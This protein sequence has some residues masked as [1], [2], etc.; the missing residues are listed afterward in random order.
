[1]TWEK[2]NAYCELKK[3]MREADNN[4]LYDNLL[5]YLGT[6]EFTRKDYNSKIP[7]APYRRTPSPTL[8]TMRRK[9]I[10]R[11]VGQETYTIEI[12]GKGDEDFAFE[13]P[14]GKILTEEQFCEI[15][16]EERLKMTVKV[17][18]VKG[19]K[20][21]EGVRYYYELVKT[22]KEELYKKSIKLLNTIFDVKG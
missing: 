17:T 19:K 8:E 20:K 10:I 3:I 2:Y 14:N 11:V 1:M 18:A 12:E 9:G 4:S 5:T 21:I 7:P 22:D 13:L 15:P 6:E 16:L